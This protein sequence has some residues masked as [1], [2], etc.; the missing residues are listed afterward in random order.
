M[1]EGVR[2]FVTFLGVCVDGGRGGH[3]KILVRLEGL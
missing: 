1:G 2:F 3:D